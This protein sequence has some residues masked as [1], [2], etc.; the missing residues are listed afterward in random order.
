[1]QV[2]SVS[3]QS[4]GAIHVSPEVI[5]GTSSVERLA[6]SRLAKK[7]ATNPVNVRVFRVA[8]NNKL[9]GYVGHEGTT[10]P[11]FLSEDSYARKL[12][13][14]SFLSKLCKKA[15]L[16]NEKKMNMEDIMLMASKVEK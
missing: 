11:I 3:S 4:F 1:M 7:E 16:I 9:A 8:G 14:Y 15:D 10:V 2:Q 13:P 12:T 5:K 6:I